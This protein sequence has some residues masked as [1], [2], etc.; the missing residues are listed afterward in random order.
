MTRLRWIIALAMAIVSADGAAAFPVDSIWLNLPL[1]EGAVRR[2]GRPTL[3]SAVPPLPGGDLRRLRD[4]E[5]LAGAAMAQTPDGRHLIVADAAGRI[6]VFALSTG[7]R[8]RR[9]Q[10]P[11]KDSAH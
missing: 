6:D 2:F 1:P 4:P 5:M 3:T 9:L 11:G 8:D 10:E 7:R